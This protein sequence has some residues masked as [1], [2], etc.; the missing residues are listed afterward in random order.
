MRRE[1]IGLLS[2]YLGLDLYRLDETSRVIGTR[3]RGSY[4]LT[5]LGQPLLGQ[6][7]GIEALR[8]KLPFPD[9]SLQ[10]MEDERVLVTLGEWPDALDTAKEF[11]PAQ[12]RELAR[13][14]EPFL[15]NER[16]GWAFIDDDSMH[17][18]IRRLCR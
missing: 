12:Y 4:W 3:A 5:F 18:W 10:P 17:R 14:L 2:R 15:Y 13:L 9:V 11:Y 16:S 7:G 8:D 6:L 1:L